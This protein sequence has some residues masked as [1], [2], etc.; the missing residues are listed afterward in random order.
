MLGTKFY[1]PLQANQLQN[2]KEGLIDNPAPNTFK[3]Y[4]EAA[5][6]C[7]ENSARIKDKGDYYEVV[8]ITEP[9]EEELALRNAQAEYSDLMQKLRNTD[10]VVI[11]I[12]E[13]VATQEEYSEILSE[14]QQWRTRV[15]ALLTQYPSLRASA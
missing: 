11:K 10:Y 6:W 5:N 7:E 13:G 15:D 12:S 3:K 4:A 8:T 2:E 1:K 14:R 9:S